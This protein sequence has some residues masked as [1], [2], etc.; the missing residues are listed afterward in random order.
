M[1]WVS[2]GGG[3]RSQAAWSSALPGEP[4][5]ASKEKCGARSTRGLSQIRDHISAT[6]SPLWIF[7]GANCRQPLVLQE[8]AWA[9]LLRTS[10]S[11]LHQLQHVL[12]HL[13][14]DGQERPEPSR[15]LP[16]LASW[17]CSEISTSAGCVQSNQANFENKCLVKIFQVSPRQEDC[18]TLNCPPTMQIMK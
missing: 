8:P 1:A 18:L 12:W 15:S 14:P 4:S 5:A 11:V 6:Q 9:L 17:H 3:G 7:L 13:R 2:R 16:G 10:F